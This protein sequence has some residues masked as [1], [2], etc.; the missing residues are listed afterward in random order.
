VGGKRRKVR[1]FLAKMPSPSPSL[2]QNREG[3]GSAGRP[4]GRGTR[5]WS[6]ARQRPGDGATR[7]GGQGDLSP[8]LTLGWGGSLG[9]LRVRARRPVWLGGGAKGRRR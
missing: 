8:V 1:G 9:R 6:R 3:G 7:R 4:A 2:V 5:R